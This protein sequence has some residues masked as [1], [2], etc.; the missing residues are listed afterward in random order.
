LFNTAYEN[1]KKICAVGTST[2]R[3][4]ETAS[5]IPG[6]IKPYDGWT[7]RFIFPPYYMQ[8]ATNLITNFHLP[9]STMLMNV[10]TFGGYDYVMNAYE[11]ALENGYKFGCYGDAML[12]VD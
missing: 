3:A 7:N 11:A 1:G 12:I 9:F 2:F 8:T 6:K 4:L 5:T 10:A